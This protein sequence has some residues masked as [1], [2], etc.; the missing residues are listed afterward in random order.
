MRFAS[1]YVNINPKSPVQQA[2]YFG[3]DKPILEAHDDLNAR[4]TY[5]ED[6][7]IVIL[8]TIDN[9]GLPLSFQLDTELQ[10]QQLF[11]KKVRLVIACSH[12]HYAGDPRDKQYRQQIQAA[13]VDGV[14]NLDVLEYQNL[15]YSFTYGF[16]DKYGTSRISNQESKLIYLEVL[17]IY[18][19]SQR[20]ANFLIYNC[21]PTLLD[22]KT[23]YFSAEYPGYV[24]AK[25]NEKYPTESFSFFQGACGDIST[26]FTRESQTYES[27]TKLGDILITK[28][29][30][31]LDK[32][33][34]K[35][36]IHLSYT[37]KYL[38]LEHEILDLDQMEVPDDLTER[39]LETVEQGKRAREILLTKIDE[40]P[41]EIMISKVGFGGYNMIF[42][43]NE[44]FSFY[45]SALNKEKA[46]LV[47]YS[48]GYGPYVT[49]IGKQRITYEL[50]TDTFSLKTKQEMFDLFKKLSNE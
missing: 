31:I 42:A 36:K 45:I 37:A 46:S 38:S 9:L 47:C 29:L 49:G 15:Y 50:F 17:S 1:G 23:A 12:T 27:L 7:E 13:I 19:D 41:P 48:N 3:Q 2:G 14:K 16:F 4:I 24:I 35:H 10:L 33:K 11:E 32:D 22:S 44:L 26:R 20:L 40:L 34:P 21:H 28:I 25:L 39:E 43:P 8:V 6:Q 5:L 30:E 18:S